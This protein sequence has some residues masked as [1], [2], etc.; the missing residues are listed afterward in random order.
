MQAVEFDRNA[1]AGWYAREHLKTDPGVREIYYLP[2]DAPEREIRF[3]EVNDLI[4]EQTDDALEPVDFGVDRGTGSEH[5]LLV[6]DVTPSQWERIEKRA[7]A[8]PAGWSLEAAVRY[9]KN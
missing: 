8:L 3:V 5:A 2:N 9:P 6:L 4:A 1:M 7:L